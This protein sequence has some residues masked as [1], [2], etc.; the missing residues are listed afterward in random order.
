MIVSMNLLALFLNESE[1]I[2]FAQPVVGG[3][4]DQLFDERLECLELLRAERRQAVNDVAALAWMTGENVF[5]GEAADGLLDG[6]RVHAELAA[7]HADGRHLLAGLELAGRNGLFYSPDDLLVD[8]L[9]QL[10][11]DQEWQH[12]TVLVVIGQVGQCKDF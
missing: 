9:A 12:A 1:E 8:R 2:R 10:E 6:V 7:D 11:V 3:L 4:D 5:L